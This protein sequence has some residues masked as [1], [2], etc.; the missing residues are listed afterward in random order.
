[1]I[2]LF[3]A[4]ITKTKRACIHHWTK[5]LSKQM[6]FDFCCR[7]FFFLSKPHNFVRLSLKMNI[8]YFCCP[9]PAIACK[10]WLYFLFCSAAAAA[11]FVDAAGAAHVV[12]I[13]ELKIE[14]QT[15]KAHNC[16]FPPFGCCVCVMKVWF[17]DSHHHWKIVWLDK[18]K[19]IA[20]ANGI[21]QLMYGGVCV[22]GHKCACD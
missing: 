10:L 1:M 19:S 7:C 6:C 21:E 9:N 8:W 14:P 13:S 22:Y 12:R 18:H 16:F 2:L 15:I 17:C 5:A 11:A 3:D 20:M 4:M